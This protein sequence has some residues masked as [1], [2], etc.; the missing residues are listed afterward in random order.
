MKTSTLLVSL[1][2]AATLPACGGAGPK[3][4]SDAKANGDATSAKNATEPS[5]GPQGPKTE[6]AA[7]V[8]SVVSGPALDDLPPPPPRNIDH[9]RVDLTQLSAPPLLVLD[10]HGHTAR[11]TSLQFTSDG[12]N[13]VSA[14]YD[15][16]IR[17]WSVQTGRLLRTLRGERGEGPAGRIYAAALSPDDRWIAVGGWLGTEAS[18]P[19]SASS[20]AFHLRLID[21]QSGN[22]QQVF[23][24]HSDVVMSVAFSHDGTRLAS[25]SGDHSAIL[26]DARTGRAERTLYGHTEGVTAVAWSPDDTLVVTGSADNSARIF[27]VRTGRQLAVLSGHRDEIHALSFTPSGRS[28]LTG[29]LDG[30]VRIWDSKSGQELKTL[31]DV[32]AP[33]A[34]LTISPSGLEVLVTTAGTPF[35]T[36]VYNINN[37]K[38][39]SVHT[40]QD[41]VV[42]A[43][44]ISPNGKWAATA[45]GSDFDVAI[46]NLATGATE[47]HSASHGSTVWNVGFQDDGSSIAWGH[48]FEKG[49]AGPYQQNGRLEYKL[50]LKD[51]NQPFFVSGLPTNQTSFVRATERA[52]GI[53]L[54]TENGREDPVLEIRSGGRIQASLRRDQTNGFVH[55]AFSLSPDGTVGVSGG[56]NGVLTSFDTAS[57][58]QLHSFEGH[59]GD[60]LSLAVSPD[61]T[62]VVSGSSDQSVRLWDLATGQLLLTVFHARN[63]EWVAYTP[64]G[65]YASSP[66]GDAYLGW[67]VGRGPDYAAAYFPASALSSQL[68]FESVVRRYIL[69]GGTIESAINAC[70]QALPVGDAPIAYYRFEDLPQFAPPDIYFLDP[71]SDLR[72]NSDR[73][74]VTARA[75]SPNALEVDSLTILINGRPIDERWMSHVGRPRLRLSGR[76]AEIVATVPLPA[77]NNRITVVAKNRYNESPAL[78]FDVE[79][80]GGPAELEQIY[81][82]DLYLLSVGVSDYGSPHL[83]P[84][85]FAHLDATAV[86]ESLQAHNQTIFRTID[87]TVLTE[88][89]ASQNNILSALGSISRRAEQKDLTIVFLSGYA[90]MAEDGNYYFVPHDAD[91]NRLK[92]TAVPLLELKKMLESLPSRVLILMDSS[93]AEV[94]SKKDQKTSVDMSRL[95]RATLASESD[96]VVMTSSSGAEVSYESDAWKHGAFT[97]ALLEGLSGQADYDRD[98]FIYVRELELY[99]SRRVPKMTGNLQHPT[100]SIPSSLPNFPLSQ[101]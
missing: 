58:R 82:P 32:S 47:V 91:T 60:I 96:V 13:L 9:P 69:L 5:A 94:L 31:A 95:L 39:I 28:I 78:S 2:L 68:H 37:G 92:E 79:R 101:R 81:K 89:Q 4:A 77:K 73:L 55:R 62:R 57:G 6:D 33:V 50:P 99:L 44:A 16:T 88:K 59:S 34:S 67:H 80:T 52:S 75:H 70:N 35:A 20:P 71:G 25:G 29:S 15:K 24:G 27:E 10:G 87:S 18:P 97:Q 11:V 48:S 36:H 8:A 84:L 54:R 90:K 46:W 98:R 30:T 1:Y 76:E 53:E 100:T 85:S 45:G 72:I 63:G 49:G 17:V 86:A 64:A 12:R 40:A 51:L 22:T 93:H 41:N 38:R 65:Y 14:G 42:A 66:F 19:T 3:V 7:Q 21:F 56:D 61:G 43:S 83:K 74:Q 23:A 26:W